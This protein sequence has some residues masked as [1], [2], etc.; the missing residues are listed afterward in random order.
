VWPHIST[1]K[2]KQPERPEARPVQ[3]IQ[4]LSS[5][6]RHGRRTAADTG[7]LQ[8]LSAL[9]AHPGLRAHRSERSGS[10]IRTAPHCSGCGPFPKRRRLF[11]GGRERGKP[12]SSRPGS[13][14]WLSRQDNYLPCTK[15]IQALLLGACNSWLLI[16]IVFFFFFPWNMKHDKWKR[17]ATSSPCPYVVSSTFP[18]ARPQPS[19]LKNN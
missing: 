6:A 10:E 5:R 17:K 14:C 13:P 1:D 12:G 7:A 16:Y 3:E 15:A 4:M 18:H 8:R 19:L 9:T 11:R 2:Q